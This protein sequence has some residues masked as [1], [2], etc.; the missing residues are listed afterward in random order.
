M[1]TERILGQYCVQ[2]RLLGSKKLTHAA[3]IV[4][5]LQKDVNRPTREQVDRLADVILWLT[6][7]FASA[8]DQP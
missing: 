1:D 3:V 2:G 4:N 8:L 7:S 6:Q 5:E